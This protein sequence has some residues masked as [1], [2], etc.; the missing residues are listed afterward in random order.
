MKI[1]WWKTKDV[2][3]AVVPYARGLAD[4]SR[5]RTLLDYFYRSVYEGRP[6]R[7]SGN[8]SSGDYARFFD[9]AQARLNASKSVADTVVNRLIKRQAL[10]I[11]TATDADWTLKTRARHLSRYVRALL[12]SSEFQALAPQIAFDAVQIGDGFIQVV[13]GA[14][15]ISFERV[16]RDELFVE[17]RELRYNMP[18]QMH[19]RRRISRYVLWEKFDDKKAR[20]AIEAAPSC[21]RSLD[22]SLG[23]DMRGDEDDDQIDVWESW[24][25]P[26]GPDADDGLVAT[27][28]EGYTLHSACWE[29]D[30]FPIVGFSWTRPSEGYWGRGMIEEGLGL[31]V[32]IDRSLSAIINNAEAMS[33]MHVFV[34]RGSA[35]PKQ[36]LAGGPRPRLVEY[37]GAVPPQFVA[38]PPFNPAQLQFLQWMM[39]QMYEM[40]GVSQATASSK[41]PLGNGASGVAL[42]N[43]MDIES[44]RFSEKELSLALFRLDVARSI[45]AVNKQG[46]ISDKKDGR[47][48]VVTW[49]DKDVMRSIDWS[50]VDLKRDQFAYRLEAT[51]FI[52]E[53]RAG[54]LST[55]NE[56]SKAGVFADPAMI[57]TLFDEPDIDRAFRMQNA[58]SNA[59]EAMLEQASDPDDD[60]PTIDPHL[61]LALIVKMGKQQYNRLLAN[62]AGKSEPG[63]EALSRVRDYI[64]L[65][66]AAI[67]KS[68]TAEAPPPAP[69]DGGMGSAP[70]M[71]PPG[72][73]PIPMGGPPMPDM[74][75][76]PPQG[77]MQ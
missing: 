18:R 23:V 33:G 2:A 15:G 41:S 24:H 1:P 52:P 44:D 20:A 47:K 72:G 29:Q 56:L 66:Q 19:R 27:C 35:T 4:R 21:D 68:K 26:S 61:D 54:K 69:P 37:D 77:A 57:S 28:I 11:M 73:P 49:D 76:M 25:L 50:D 53:T 9:R 7:S 3:A 60:M 71:P 34:R 65:A 42:D 6:F 8:S 10:P 74:G 46:A 40:P 17:P 22:R 75:T 31:Q 45:V 12:M 58:A 13:D 39:S 36:H 38:P 16:P 43:M 14:D 55:I 48:R 59:V 62:R 67:D 32:A 64:E 70:P 30:V 5:Q 51:N 63:R